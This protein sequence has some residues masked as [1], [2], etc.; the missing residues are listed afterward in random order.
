MMVLSVLVGR[1]PVRLAAL[2]VR[3]ES[4]ETGQG[5]GGSI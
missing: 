2:I 5:E 3:A 4:P 1:A